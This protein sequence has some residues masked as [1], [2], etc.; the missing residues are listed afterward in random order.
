[1]KPFN[2]EAAINGAKVIDPTDNDVGEFLTELKTVT[3]YKFV[4]V[5]INQDGNQYIRQVDKRGECL[6]TTL[7]MAPVEH[8]GYI[9]IYPKHQF[10]GSIHKTIEE[11]NKYATYDRVSVATVE[12]EE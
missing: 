4:F 7:K 6:H 1:M 9:N 10:H 5:M 11:A 12:W 2:L 3:D 8:K